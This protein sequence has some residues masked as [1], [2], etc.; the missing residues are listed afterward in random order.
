MLLAVLGAGAMAWTSR[1]IVGFVVVPLAVAVAA[2]SQRAYPFIGRVSLWTVPLLATLAASGLTAAW[3]FAVDR[4]EGDRRVWLALV[5]AVAV[6]LPVAV[7]GVR[8][9]VAPP[10]VE[11]VRP[12]VA[13]LAG[14]IEP[15]DVVLVD[16]YSWPAFTYDADR[17]D[18]DGIDARKVGDDEPTIHDQLPDVDGRD[19]VWVLSSGSFE[20]GPPG[21]TL[22]PTLDA[23]GTRVATFDEDGAVLILYD[24]SD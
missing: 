3:R 17:I 8:Q 13:E 15:G 7:A 19:R 16:H 4:F 23:A 12:L 18:L 22:T 24:L 20:G 11:E 9:G 1:R 5:P 2:S 14:R 6:L 21:S 10:G